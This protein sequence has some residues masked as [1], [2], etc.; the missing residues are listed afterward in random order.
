MKARQ[1]TERARVSLGWPG[2]ALLLQL[3]CFQSL[4]C[5]PPEFPLFVCVSLCVSSE[6]KNLL[7]NKEGELVYIITTLNSRESTHH[8]HRLSAR[9]AYQGR[10]QERREANEAGR[11]AENR[12]EERHRAGREVVCKWPVDLFLF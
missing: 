2:L 9:V 5:F 12:R 7:G 4:T 10:E 3:F 8:K 6:R 11:A 1:R